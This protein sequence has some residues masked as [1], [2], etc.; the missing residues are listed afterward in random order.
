LE[1]DASEAAKKYTTAEL[2]SQKLYVMY[3]KYDFRVSSICVHLVCGH[4]FSYMDSPC[5]FSCILSILVMRLAVATKA[6]SVVRS[7]KLRHVN[8]GLYLD[9]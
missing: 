7:V 6:S 9:G 5:T 2:A 1:T 3:S 4:L 8:L